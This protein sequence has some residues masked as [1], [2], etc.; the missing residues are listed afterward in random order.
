MDKNP[1]EKL[2][3]NAEAQKAHRAVYASLMNIGI[4]PKVVDTF[5]G[6][7]DIIICKAMHDTPKGTAHV[8]IPVELENGKALMP[9][10]FFSQAGFKDIERNDYIEHVTKTA[11]KAFTVDGS[12]LL[13]VLEQVK[14]AGQEV[15]SDVE[16]AA[17]KVASEKGTVSMDPNAILYTELAE[18]TPDVELPKMAATEESSFA[19]SLGKPEGIAKFL[20]S[21]RVV[22]AGRSIIIRKISEMGFG[23]PQVKVSDSDEKKIYYAVAIG[24]GTGLKVPVE[25]SGSMVLPPTIAFADDMITAFSKEAIS[26]IVKSGT[27]G[28]VRALATASPCYDLKASELVD[29]A[30]ESINEGNFTRAEEA[31]NVL[32]AIN[33]EAQKTAIAYM[34][35]NIYE[36]GQDPK[37]DSATMKAIASK[38]V[39][40]TPYLNNYNIFFPKDA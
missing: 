33:P 4:E 22:E 21:E 5:A 2:Y 10:M 30:K 34:M 6:R 18:I 15:V 35:L 25:V 17:I 3:S 39:K 16:L 20:H 28:N 31:I 29:I 1:T 23:T 19:E 40:D 13:S 7:G 14:N 37:T 26:E 11:G 12:K 36:P 32:G 8:I 24:T 38:P 27:G 9:T